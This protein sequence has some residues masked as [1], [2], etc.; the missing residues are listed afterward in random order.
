MADPLY[1]PWVF[2]APCLKPEV[3]AAWWQAILSAL[4]ILAASRLARGQ[5]RRQ[6]SRK[7]DVIVSMLDSADQTTDSVLKEAADSFRSLQTLASAASYR[8][9]QLS[10]TL[11]SLAL[12]ELPDYRLLPVVLS[13][14]SLCLHLSQEMDR[15]R[16][17]KQMPNDAQFLDAVFA[18]KDALTGYY[19]EA[20]EIA[21]EHHDRTPKQWFAYARFKLAGRDERDGH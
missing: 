21:N 1:C 17:M 19:N 11:D 3:W 9:Q 6:L 10:K 18:G 12:Q 14:A 16:A 5:E 20:A 8:Y 7:A 15:I 2:D 4:A 13:G